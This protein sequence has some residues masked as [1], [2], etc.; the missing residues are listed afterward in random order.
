MGLRHAVITSVD[1][2]DLPDGGA[3]SLRRGD[4]G[5]PPAHPGTRGRGADARLPR[6]AG[7]PRRGAGGASRGLLPQRRDGARA[8]I[9]R[10]APGAATSARSRCWPK[11]RGG[12][13]R[14]ATAGGSRPASCSASAR[15]PTR[16][17]RRCGDIRGAG[18]EILTIGQ[19]LQ[20]TTR[21]LPVD[22]WVHPGRVRRATASRRS[23]W[24]SPTA[25]RARW[26]AARYHAHEHVRCRQPRS[27]RAVGRARRESPEPAVA[28]R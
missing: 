5:D 2:D 11:R 15:A 27:T 19:Y 21:H 16:S 7:R 8:S 20:P 12:A 26:C 22:R 28:G 13:T 18:V 17:S 10:R 1:R 14:A 6:R 23:P 24:A 25:R 9:A 4:R 3:A